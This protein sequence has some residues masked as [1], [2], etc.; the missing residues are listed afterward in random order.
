MAEDLVN[1]SQ[2]VERTLPQNGLM[3]AGQASLLQRPQRS[4]EIAA[5]NAGYKLVAERLQREIVV[6]IQEMAE[7]A[8]QFFD[9]AQGLLCERS[10]LRHGQVA[11]F[12]RCLAR[13]EQEPEIGGRYALR[14]PVWGLLDVVRYEPV[15]VFA[16][17]LGEVP[18][19]AQGDVS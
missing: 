4:D 16:A 15:I 1:V 7:M 13:V 5:I 9:R 18:P 19:S 3:Q 10:K 2:A 14:D 17:E 8:R 11:E 12:E 6:P